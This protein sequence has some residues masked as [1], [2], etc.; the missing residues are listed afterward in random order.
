[1]QKIINSAG[2]SIIGKLVKF[3]GDTFEASKDIPVARL[4]NE[5]LQ[6][7]VRGDGEGG[8]YQP[9]NLTT[10]TFSLPQMRYILFTRKPGH[11]QLEELK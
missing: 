6:A 5:I 11:S 9:I 8:G 10:P 7:F 2:N 1:M 4:S 3:E